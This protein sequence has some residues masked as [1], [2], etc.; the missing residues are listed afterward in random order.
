VEAVPKTVEGAPLV[1][2]RKIIK[3]EGYTIDTVGDKK[4]DPDSPN[5]RLILRVS[6]EEKKPIEPD[7]IALIGRDGKTIKPEERD[8]H[9]IGDDK[10]SGLP[11]TVTPGVTTGGGTGV[12]VGVD[13]GGL[14]GGGPYS[15][16]KIDFKRT[17]F[18]AG[19]KIKI[20]MPGK[21]ELVL[22]LT[23]IAK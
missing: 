11:M 18:V 4:Q 12:G 19:A 23:S 2:A 3:K 9:D 22:P 15:Y 13:L 17:D 20:V 14:F 1:P 16:T 7:E 5:I 6:G 10:D 21:R 8:D